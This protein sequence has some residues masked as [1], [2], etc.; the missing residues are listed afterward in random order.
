MTVTETNRQADIVATDSPDPIVIIG[1]GP[2]GIRFV[3]ELL[4][5]GCD[6]PVVIFGNEPWAPYDRIRLSSLLAGDVDVSDIGVASHLANTVGVTWHHNCA[7]TAID[8]VGKVII[9][10]SG[11]RHRYGKLVLATGST[12]HRPGIPGID[13]ERVYTFRDL[14]DT[15][16]LLARSARTR[17]VV[18][19][20]G[21]LLGLETARAM[22]R[23]ATQVTVVQQAQHLMNRQ[24][25]AAAAKILETSLLGRGMRVVTGAGVREI[26]T[27]VKGDRCSPVVTGVRLR[28][29]EVI[30]CDTVIVSAG[31]KPNVDL[32]IDARMTVARGIVV[33]DQLRSSDESIFAIGE[34][35]EF[36]GQLYGL[37]A[38]GFEQAAV[39]AAGL[40]HEST[41]YGGSINAT[42]LKVVGLPVFSAGDIDAEGN[43]WRLLS[44]TYTD[45]SAGCYRKLVLSRGCLVGAIGIG[46]WSEIKRVQEAITTRRKIGLWQLL[47]FRLT[48]KLWGGGSGSGVATWPVNALV[49]N[50]RGVTRGQLSDAFARSGNLDVVVTTTGASSVCGS[51]QPLVAELCGLGDTVK[52]PPIQTALVTTAILAFIATLVYAS[53]PPVPYAGTAQVD[54]DWGRLW[55]DGLFKQISGFTLLGLSV[56]GLMLSLNKRVKWFSFGQFSA[57]RYLHVL[58][59]LIC[60]L[61]LAAHTGLRMGENLN[62]YL[63]S[64][65]LILALVGALS[66]F[67]IGGERWMSARAGRTAR[68]WLTWGHIAVFWPLPTLLAFHVISVYYF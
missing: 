45:G 43:S 15:Q 63:M 57:W 32:A 37:V 67:V 62:A 40:C 44:T 5:R 20:G 49:C 53:L 22:Q 9:D 51:C 13:A 35:A 16:Q 6:R 38:P 28:S 65:F 39:L 46:E 4:R 10:E 23:A 24:L 36:N 1:A 19:I 31:I 18:V 17:H 59:G 3:E 41:S 30:D 25:D 26:I 2:V 55:S 48:G 56:I 21:G 61:V 58:L 8:R 60:L 7:V 50:C 64:N 12:P 34:C 11:R 47:R 54:I 29:G 68:Q 42:Q 66:A 27:E 14:T 52:K 33:D